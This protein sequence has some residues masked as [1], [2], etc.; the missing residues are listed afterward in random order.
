[1]APARRSNETH[2]SNDRFQSLLAEASAETDESKRSG[3]IFEM[4]SLLRDDGGAII[5]VF[6]DWLDAHHDSV[7]GHTP[8]GGFELDNGAILEKAFLRAG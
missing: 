6:R 7:G 8:H 3:P 4:Q 1:M 2:W 5:P